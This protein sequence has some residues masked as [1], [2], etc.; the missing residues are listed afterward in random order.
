MEPAPQPNLEFSDSLD[1]RNYL[2]ARVVAI[3]SGGKL[4]KGQDTPSMLGTGYN[5]GYLVVL[6]QKE[7]AVKDDVTYEHPVNKSHITHRVTHVKPGFVYVQGIGNRGGDGWI[8]IE[9]VMGK[10]IWPKP[11]M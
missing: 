5:R 4:Y 2:D 10:V 9:K 8:P 11:K 3:S 1:P 6:P 7:Y